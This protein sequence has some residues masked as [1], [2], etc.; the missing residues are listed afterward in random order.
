MDAFGPIDRPTIPRRSVS[1]IA[2]A[3]FGTEPRDD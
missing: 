3:F 2:A 1:E